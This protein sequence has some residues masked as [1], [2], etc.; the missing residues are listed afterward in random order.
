MVQLKISRMLERM[1]TKL[2]NA[3]SIAATKNVASMAMIVLTDD[4]LKQFR[5]TFQKHWSDLLDELIEIK[6]LKY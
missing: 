2:S 1:I 5:K 4:E 3:S 6:K